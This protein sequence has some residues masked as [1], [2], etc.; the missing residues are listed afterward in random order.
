MQREKLY[1][2]HNKAYC[3]C[4]QKQAKCCATNF[5][6]VKMW[7]LKVLSILKRKSTTIKKWSYVNRRAFHAVPCGIFCF[8]I[9]RIR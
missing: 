1:N 3:N 4:F 8:L 2:L 6:T 5:R 7:L 9:K